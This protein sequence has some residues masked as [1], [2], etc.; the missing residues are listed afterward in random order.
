MALAKTSLAAYASW[1]ADL[2]VYQLGAWYG[3][4]D[5]VR[6]PYLNQTVAGVGSGFGAAS[7]VGFV[8][9]G[10]PGNTTELIHQ[11]AKAGMGALDPMD[12]VDTVVGV[13]E[14]PPGP[15]TPPYPRW[16]WVG[17]DEVTVA[18]SGSIST[19]S[20]YKMR[21]AEPMPDFGDSGPDSPCHPLHLGMK[22]AWGSS[23]FTKAATCGAASASGGGNVLPPSW[24][25][26]GG[27]TADLG[28]VAFSLGMEDEVL[29]NVT[30]LV[31]RL[32]SCVVAGESVSFDGFAEEAFGL[33]VVGS[34]DSLSLYMDDPAG[35]PLYG[36]AVQASVY[37]PIIIDY[38]LKCYDWGQA[39]PG[40][41]F[42]IPDQYGGY[43]VVA[44][45]FAGQRVY[46]KASWDDPVRSRPWNVVVDLDPDWA[47]AVY[48]A[49][50]PNDLP[51]TIEESGLSCDPDDTLDSVT[52]TRPETLAVQLPADA[53]GA[54]PSGWSTASTGLSVTQDGQTTKVAVG[55]T[56][57]GGEI[58]RDFET[59]YYER[60][61]APAA[62]PD[63][64]LDLLHAAGDD[65]WNWEQYK[66]LKVE[67]ENDG[68]SQALTLTVGYSEV[69]VSDNHLT[70]STRIGEF[71]YTR[72]EK[73]AAWTF[74]AAGP[75]GSV[76]LDLSYPD[77]PWLQHVDSLTLT[78]FTGD[79]GGSF[80]FRVMDIALTQWD[81]ID[82]TA[83]GQVGIKV[84]FPRPGDGGLPISYTAFTAHADGDRAC[85]P[86][87][88]IAA[89]CGEQG[90]DFVEYLR[91]AETGTI[92]DYM[93]SATQ[94]YNVL[95]VQEGFALAGGADLVNGGAGFDALFVDAGYDMLGQLYAGD[96]LERIDAGG[97][98][99]SWVAHDYESV[100]KVRPRV[101]TVY[102][103]SGVPLEVRVRK[104]LRGNLHGIVRD[105]G[106]FERVGADVEVKLWADGS[107]LQM[108]LTNHWS[109]AG[110]NAD[111]GGRE[112]SD[113]GLTAGAAAGAPGTTYS[114]VRNELRRW[115]P[116]E[117]AVAAGAC[118]NMDFDF[119]GTL[120][121]VVGA[122]PGEEGAVGCAY[123]FPSVGVWVDVVAPF[124]GEVWSRP[125]VACW[126]NG[127]LSC[128]ATR[129]AD[130]TADVSISRDRGRSW[131][132]FT[133][134]E[135]TAGLENVDHCVR[136]CVLYVVGWFAELEDVV[137]RAS[138]DLAALTTDVLYTD[139]SP[140]E[141]RKVC[142]AP[143]A[144]GAAPIVTI[145]RNG[146]GELWVCVGQLS[147]VVE[148]YNCRAFFSGFGKKV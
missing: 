26:S 54:L 136:N 33:R 95:A 56:A 101:G 36:A 29:V 104:M 71:S 127:W 72:T 53:G 112:T 132:V 43:E 129:A 146:A 118:P 4:G 40:A 140:Y 49:V 98:A 148:T 50:D 89:L 3:M 79:P 47:N 38:D 52:I 63:D 19:L 113:L 141:T 44:A 143:G 83:V 11:R 107:V 57:S 66:F 145:E 134:P 121:R 99:G 74:D 138:S 135:L 67:W 126:W 76:V 128:V 90:I 102:P 84:V 108:C 8:F 110:F 94:F 80:E 85:R 15:P 124:A 131:E 1:S 120:W 86:P 25:A 144:T 70:D 51:C 87:D 93:R 68:P 60:L 42:A 23:D 2:T 12:E 61:D 18:L 125:T 77:S 114:Y 27:G 73:T 92:L 97:D 111:G 20:A 122:R 13:W 39:Y 116:L 5:E 62:L 7:A 21:D 65:V 96:F 137:V 106:T 6:L 100:L 28:F 130:G 59:D 24:A 34:G 69:V 14:L 82:S 115:C 64:Y 16:E 75:T 22:Y 10:F 55:T 119:S 30:G 81:P 133:S 9:S 78:G 31:A 32:S 17:L 117:F 58:T 142:D 88:Q 147:G 48:E 37:F 109:W 139:G 91:G 45:P 46:G 35:V 103:A 123:L 41:Q 105:S